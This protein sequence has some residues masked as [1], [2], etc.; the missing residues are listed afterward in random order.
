M[1]IGRTC[2][3]DYACRSNGSY[4]AE[5]FVKNLTQA[6]QIKLSHVLQ[7]LIDTGKVWN[8]EKFKKLEGAIWEIKADHNRLLCFNHKNCWFLTNGF[9]KDSQKTKRTHIELAVAIMNEHLS[10]K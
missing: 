8:E 7:R 10:R 6:E 3:L 1:Y 9:K 4:P 2:N 5:E